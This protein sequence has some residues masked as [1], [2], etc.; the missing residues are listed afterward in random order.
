MPIKRVILDTNLWISFLI[1]D[2]YKEI[3]HLIKNDQI[4]LIF[5]IELLDEFIEVVNRP[6]FNKYFKDYDIIQL[7]NMFDDFAILVDVHSNLDLCRDKKDNFL[8]NLAKDSK[9]DYL[10]TGDQDLLFLE[11]ID[12]CKII[13]YSNFLK[14]MN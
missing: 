13:Q 5:S 9:S 14:E 3:D 1:N 11:R 6:K 4:K 8:L 7:L 10:I 12:N 2:S